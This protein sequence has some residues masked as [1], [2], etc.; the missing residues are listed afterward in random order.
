M[1][2]GIV[3]NHIMFTKYAVVF[4]EYAVVD[5]CPTSNSVYPY[6]LAGRVGQ[7]ISVV[8]FVLLRKQSVI[9][10][11]GHAACDCSKTQP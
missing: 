7:R 11:F 1:V 3:S 6:L 5:N 2:F 10:F 4:V 8:P 9:S